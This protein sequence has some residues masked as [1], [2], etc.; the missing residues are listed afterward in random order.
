MNSLR[1]FLF[2][3]L[4]FPFPGTSFGSDSSSP[5]QGVENKGESFDFEV[6]LPKE[7]NRHL[8]INLDTDLRIQSFEVIHGAYPWI[9]TTGG[10]REGDRIVFIDGKDFT[11]KDFKI[12]L[13]ALK[14]A[15]TITVRPREGK[16]RDVIHAQSPKM[17]KELHVETNEGHMDVLRGHLVLFTAPV[18]IADF[19]GKPGYG[20]SP[21]KIVMA[22]PENGCSTLLN[23]VDYSDHENAYILAFRG[24]CTF[25]AKGANAESVGAAGLIIMN[26][27][28]RRVEMPIDPQLLSHNLKIP[29]VMVSQSDGK[30]ILH[31]HSTEMGPILGRMAI[32]SECLKDDAHF[33]KRFDEEY[34]KDL[35]AVKQKERETI[36]KMR[37]QAGQRGKKAE[38]IVGAGGYTYVGLEDYKVGGIEHE[39]RKRTRRD[40]VSVELAAEERVK[41]GVESGELFVKEKD[42]VEEVWA[43]EYFTVGVG[44]YLPQVEDE[45]VVFVLRKE[46][47]IGCKNVKEKVMNK[48]VKERVGRVMMFDVGV[49]CTYRDAMRLGSKLKV[50]AVVLYGN[51][52]EGMEGEDV[53]NMVPVDIEDVEV[54]I[55]M[56]RNLD[57][58]FRNMLREDF[59]AS[60][61]VV[62]YGAA[63]ALVS[64]EGGAVRFEADNLVLV[65]WNDIRRI[66]SPSSWPHD[67]RQRGRMER[68]MRNV[69]S[70]ERWPERNKV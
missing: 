6:H 41:G 39:V 5:S 7:K 27:D 1:I 65:S 49:D 34:L 32:T 23:D 40:A 35:E 62:S 9:Y 12:S 55:E 57:E 24:G 33:H 2:L 56:E 31:S 4:L 52:V 67:S 44:G 30:S 66:L 63:K 26:N 8:G 16:P 29:V 25:S 37:S 36:D 19:S 28:N 10:V 21:K 46:D 54:D 68:K 18:M 59:K 3:L 22:N 15:S 45:A 53:L 14:R 17:L 69:H 38:A 50:D 47:M 51:R 42:G 11:R 13:R 48:V 43:M 61:V 70:A 64:C 20:C 58:D 60:V